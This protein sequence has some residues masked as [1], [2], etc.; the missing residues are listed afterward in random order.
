MKRATSSSP[1]LVSVFAL[2]GPLMDSRGRLPPTPPE[3]AAG[4][5]PRPASDVHGAGALLHAALFPSAGDLTDR[6]V[7]RGIG[8]AEAPVALASCRVDIS[9]RLSHLIQQTRAL[10]WCLRPTAAAIAHELSS[11]DRW[12]R[13]APCRHA[14][15]GSGSPS[16]GAGTGALQRPGPRLVLQALQA[17]VDTDWPIPSRRHLRSQRPPIQVEAIEQRPA[18][19][20]SALCVA[21]S[22]RTNMSH[23]ATDSPVK[24]PHRVSGPSWTGVPSPPEP[25]L[26]ADRL[27]GAGVTVTHR[28]LADRPALLIFDALEDADPLSLRWLHRLLNTEQDLR[29]IAICDERWQTDE[30]RR[31]RSRLT[32]RA[33]VLDLTM[34]DLAPDN[35]QRVVDLISRS[36]PNPPVKAFTEPASPARAT[37]EGHKILADWRGEPLPPPAVAA[38]IFGLIERVPTAP[39]AGSASTLRA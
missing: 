30:L 7:P 22:V 38:T 1:T 25:N 29:C 16:P 26:D 15:F 17:A 4:W 5:G 19:C 27:I 39:S 3:V 20:S 28:A 13:P 32:D 35:V 12:T 24:N 6:T 2:V 37:E 11:V 21:W 9:A 34:P 36:V 31:M 18:A 33:A 23:V 14:P 8:A 10:D